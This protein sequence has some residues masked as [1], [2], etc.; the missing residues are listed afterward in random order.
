ML[1]HIIDSATWN[2]TKL[3]HEYRPQRFDVEGFIHLSTKE[4]VLRPAN[5]LY[6]G[7]QNLLLLVIDPGKLDAEVVY[8][9]GSH[10]EDELF[11]H[12]YGPLNIDAVT[13]HIEF[14]CNSDGSFSLPGGLPDSP[15]AGA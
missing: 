13:G 9:A 12:L 8:E 14:P 10:G 1:F 3:Q 11:P 2:V 7:Q 4:Q 5:L 6:A 15:S